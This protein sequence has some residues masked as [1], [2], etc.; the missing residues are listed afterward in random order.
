MT[1]YPGELFDGMVDFFDAMA[2]SRWYG[3]LLADFATWAAGD[4]PGGGRVLD[5]GCGPGRLLLH[6]APRFDEAAG[7]DLS[8]GMLARAAEHARAAGRDQIR[9]VQGDA[10]ALPFD[11][12]S[13]DLVVS[14]LVVFLLEDPAAAVAELARVT[15]PGGRVALLGPSD[16]CT[17]DIA[18]GYATRRGLEGFDA[19]SLAQWGRV[20]A[21]NRRDDPDSLAALLA[22]SGLCMVD[23]WPRLGGLAL[24]ARARRPGGGDGVGG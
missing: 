6:L 2:R 12:G 15:V 24:L 10:R 23:V 4:L 20:A 13:F 19:E 9:F 8:A 17:P 11:D 22:G 7:V 21:R 18:A 16:R 1:R 14:S 3:P 5:V